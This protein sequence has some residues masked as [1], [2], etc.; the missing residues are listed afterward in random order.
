MHTTVIRLA[1]LNEFSSSCIRVHRVKYPRFFFPLVPLYPTYNSNDST[2]ATLHKSMSVYKELPISNRNFW[3]FL[4]WTNQRRP[5]MP[6]R[7]NGTAYRLNSDQSET[8]T[9]NSLHIFRPPETHRQSVT[10]SQLRSV[11]YGDSLISE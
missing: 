5:A 2:T 11:E 4:T 3:T 7:A 8:N 6:V 9:T 10:A 1:A